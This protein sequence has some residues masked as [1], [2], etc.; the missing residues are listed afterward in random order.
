MF[1]LFTWQ[2]TFFRASTLKFLGTIGPS[3]TSFDS[4]PSATPKSELLAGETRRV[5]SH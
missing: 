1:A 5:L 3:D 2:G 4:G